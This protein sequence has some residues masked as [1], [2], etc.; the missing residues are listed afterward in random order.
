M[1]RTTGSALAYLSSS[2]IAG[3]VGIAWSLASTLGV[4][5]LS[6]T[7]LGGPAFLGAT[8]VT[9]RLADLERRRAGWVLGTAIASPYLPV[10]ARHRPA[11]GHRR[12]RATRHLA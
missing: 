2:L 3:A 6:I 10:E 5:L 4:G 8:W 7:Q 11:A 9:R 12:R 1:F